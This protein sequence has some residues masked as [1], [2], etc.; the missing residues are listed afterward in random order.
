VKLKIHKMLPGAIVPRYATPGA[1]AF[2]LHTID[3]QVIQPGDT[4]YINTGLAF[5]PEPGYAVIVNVRS[6]SAKLGIALAN[7]QGWIDP[8]YR[9]AVIVALRN[10]SPDAQVGFAPGDRIAQAMIVPVF[11][12]DFEVVDA[13]SETARG[14]GG[15]GSTGS[16]D[17]DMDGMSNFPPRTLAKRRELS[18]REWAALPANLREGCTVHVPG[19]GDLL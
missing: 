10:T 12:V 2:D 4:R 13:L 9:G 6:S 14:A 19:V 5:E 3:A 11:Q 8:D 15:F 16:R 17:S 7:T 1:M 18:D